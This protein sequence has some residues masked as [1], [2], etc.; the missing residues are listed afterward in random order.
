MN[1][2]ERVL[3]SFRR[4]K[5][6]RIAILD[7]PWDETI[8]RWQ[9]EGLPH[10]VH[11][12]EYF[13]FDFKRF[14]IDVPLEY[15]DRVIAD[16][17]FRL[18]VETVEDADEYTIIRDGNGT[19]IRNWKHRTT[20]PEMM[21]FTIRDRKSWDKC[22]ERLFI[23][24]GRISTSG[25]ARNQKTA[26]EGYFNWLIVPVG[27]DY[28][29]RF[30]GSEDL[31]IALALDPA[32]CR[33]MFDAVAEFVIQLYERLV[34]AGY[35]FDGIM[36]CDDQGYRN[37]LLFSNACY[38]QTLM[39]SHIRICNY[40]HARNMPVTLHSCGNVMERIEYFIKVGFDCLHP[41]EVKAGMNPIAIKQQYGDRITLMG[42]ID[43]RNM[44]L[45]D[46]AV[47]EEE[48]RTK[49]NVLLNGGGYIY[50]SDHSIPDNVSFLQ[51]R[52]V[53]QIVKKYSQYESQ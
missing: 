34:R 40:F 52:N 45:S 29:Q 24:D 12:D 20:T 11:P 35:G 42:G 48:I 22:R 41:L 2:R 6:D 10:G 25:F 50:H 17:S 36:I 27:Y 32:W 9:N 7:S 43:A 53:I 14:Y 37:G 15:T 31:L 18:P 44:A 46:P 38:E 13:N 26:R 1:C 47:I 30:M 23:D 3:K 8:E 5:T 49:Y 28:V 33:E 4:E 51:F 39:D 21:D 16:M 19:M